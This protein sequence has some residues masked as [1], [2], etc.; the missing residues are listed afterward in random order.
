MQ[1]LHLPAGAPG[2]DHWGLIIAAC[3]HGCTHAHLHTDVPGACAGS[4]AADAQQEQQ[5]QPELVAEPPAQPLAEPPAAKPKKKKGAKAAVDF[6]A[7]LTDIDGQQ[8]GRALVSAGGH[9]T[10][11][12]GAADRARVEPGAYWLPSLVMNR[13]CCSSCALRCLKAAEIAERS[14]VSSPSCADRQLQPL[15]AH[16]TTA[17]WQGARLTC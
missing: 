5:A 12:A 14:P 10:D 6:D 7:L 4:S 3:A 15:S 9:A 16:D 1:R 17:H 13:L 8:Q 11:D 2:R